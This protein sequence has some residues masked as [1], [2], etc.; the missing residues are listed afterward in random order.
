[1][2]SDCSVRYFDVPPISLGTFFVT[3]MYNNAR[4]PGVP[5]LLLTNLRL[6][7][8]PSL[9]FLSFAKDRLELLYQI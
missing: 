4:G 7:Y 9:C 8:F 1:M 6:P 3:Y 2:G 5:N